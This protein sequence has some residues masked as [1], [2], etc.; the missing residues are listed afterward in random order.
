MARTNRRREPNEIINTKRSIKKSFRRGD[1]K[2][3][4]R[5]LQEIDPKNPESWSDIEA[6]ELYVKWDD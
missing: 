3:S 2:N 4:R 1:R 6:N 5:M